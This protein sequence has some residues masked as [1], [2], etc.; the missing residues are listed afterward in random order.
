MTM[1]R[2]AAAVG[3]AAL[4]VTMS[5]CGADNTATDTAASG[6]DVAAALTPA[7]FT[8]SVT[9]A[10]KAVKSAHMDATVTFGGQQGS[11][12]GDFSGS[13]DEPS[14]MA[15]DMR[16]KVAGKDVEIRLVKQV[17]YVHAPG[18]PGHSSKPWLKLDLSDPSNPLSSIL[19]S[20]N[21]KSFTSYLQAVKGFKDRGAETVD[22]VS[23]RHYTVTIVTAKAMAD[24][25]AFKGQ[26]LSKLGLPKTVTGDV[27]LNSDNLPVKMVVAIGSLGSF[28]AHF[29]KY[30]EPVSIDAPPANQVGSFSLPS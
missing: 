1:Q 22:G 2:F 28:E 27:W 21:P 14:S 18:M 9:A 7:N 26:D 12:S 3:A 17:L 5:A 30:G 19:D 20:A 11:I 24:S 23:T 10:Q 15:M 16:L 4:A 25:P 13:P 6:R 29:S 8:Q